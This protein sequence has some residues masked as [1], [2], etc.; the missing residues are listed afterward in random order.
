MQL[1]LSETIAL[2][3]LV[4]DDYPTWRPRMKYLPIDKDLWSAITDESSKTREGKD[5]DKSVKALA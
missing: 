2:L 1:W 3:P 4:V 5:E